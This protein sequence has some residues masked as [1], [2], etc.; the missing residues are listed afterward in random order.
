MLHHNITIIIITITIIT[1]IIPGS[2]LPA[3]GRAWSISPTS[4]TW[5]SSAFEKE[6]LLTTT[7]ERQYL[8]FG[9][10]WWWRCHDQKNLNH[11]SENG[12]CRSSQFKSCCSD[13]IMCGTCRSTHHHHLISK[14]LVLIRSCVALIRS[15]RT[16]EPRNTGWIN[17]FSQR[18]VKTSF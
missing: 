11:D 1:V 15:P 9:R 3:T 10:G 8:R 14:A 4:A 16:T 5:L 12:T 7:L 6:K 18:F 17:T 13:Q 2:S